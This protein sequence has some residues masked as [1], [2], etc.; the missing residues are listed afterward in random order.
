MTVHF[1][2]F[3][4]RFRV[5]PP[6]ASE[7]TV[8]IYARAYIMML[9]S[10]QLFGDK[11]ANRVHIR[12]LPFVANLDGM[13]R[14]SWG[15]AALAWWS[16][17][18]PPNDGKEQRV[19]RY[20]LALDRLTARDIVWEP[21]SALDVLAV[22]HPEIL[23]EEHSRMWRAVTALIYFAVIEWH[24]VDRVVPQLGGVQHTPEDAL[25][26]DWLHAKDG[27]GGDRWFPHYYQKW[28]EHWENRLDAVISIERVADPGPSADYLDWWYREAQR[29]L[30]PGAAFADPRGTQIP[31]EAYQRGSSQV[32]RRSQLPDMPDNRRVERRRRVGT[33]DTGR[34]W[35]WLHD[36]M[37]EDD[38]GGD[39]RAEVDHRVRRAN[40]RRGR[41]PDDTQHAG[42]VS[43]TAATE[44]GGDTFT[45]RAYSQMPEFTP[46]MTMDLDDQLVSPRFYADFAELI[47]NDAGT[48]NV[49]FGGQSYQQQMPDVQ[50]ETGAY[51]PHMTEMHSQPHDYQ[52]QYG[53]DLNVPA[54]S[55]LDTWF[56]M[57]GTPQ[58]AYGLDPPR[59]DVGQEAARPTRVRRPARCGTGS[60]LLGDFHDVARDD[61][62]G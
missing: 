7:E 22:V 27:R 46:T 9:L 31:P 8:R 44:A 41:T 16:A 5:L 13:G 58:S 51:Q 1:T 34:E 28:H 36:A 61:R 49:Q 24:Q 60:H 4:E 17:Y 47:G 2:W 32:P 40:A 15:S 45:S 18:L 38:A 30:S 52:G 11:S 37:Q 55:P 21:Y 29:F 53:V 62:D 12:W 10:T 57:G 20:R 14:Y 43:G 25:N 59:D 3:H 48:S 19:I 35:R 54:G 50:M 33:R 42:G 26:V 6:D 56:T 23:T 39:A